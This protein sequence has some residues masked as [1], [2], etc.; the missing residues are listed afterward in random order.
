MISVAEFSDDVGTILAD[1][2]P[3]IITPRTRRKEEHT[4]TGSRTAAS[5]ASEEKARSSTYGRKRIQD[6]IGPRE[7][8]R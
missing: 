2:R 8:A 3:S 1:S 6:R 7:D 5:P 4:A